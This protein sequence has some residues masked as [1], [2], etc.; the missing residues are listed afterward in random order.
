MLLMSPIVVHSISGKYLALKFLGGIAGNLG[1]T[2]IEAKPRISAM[3]M[4]LHAFTD[5]IWI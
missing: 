1:G 4:K 2:W 5:Y 3:K